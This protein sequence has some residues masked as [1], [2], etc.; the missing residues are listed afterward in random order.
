MTQVF[1]YSGLVTYPFERTE[2]VRLTA[3]TQS[4]GEI[5]AAL[6]ALWRNKDVD[7]YIFKPTSHAYRTARTYIKAMYPT[8]LSLP[9]PDIDS[10]GT[11]GIIIQWHRSGH[12]VIL[13]CRPERNQKDFIYYE[14]DTSGILDASP[15][16]LKQRLERL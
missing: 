7:D 11:G 6:D 13:G 8:G 5:F 2:L 3:E 12:V 10:D 14:R 9:M 16:N 15:L 4:P 1:S